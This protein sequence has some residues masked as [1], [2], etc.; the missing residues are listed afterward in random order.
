MLNVW[1][2]LILLVIILIVYM[3]TFKFVQNFILQDAYMHINELEA[4]PLNFTFQRNRGID[5][6]LNRLPCV[7]D[8]QCRDNCVISSAANELTCQDGFCNAS[9]ALVNAQVPDLIECDPRL[10]LVHVFSAGGDFV[11]SQTCVSTYRDLVDDTGTPRP[12]LCNDGRL[13]MNLNTVQFSPDA[14]ECSS[15]YEK[16]LFRQTALAR[17]IPVCIPNRMANLY[18]RVYN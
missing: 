11:V 3:Y 18:R 7:T 12:Y 13:I 2:I 9:D 15:G 8:Q 4:P 17:T 16:M 14:C 10:G 1:Q 5:C 6:S